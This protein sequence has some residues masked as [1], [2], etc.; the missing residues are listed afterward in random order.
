[1][2]NGDKLISQTWPGPRPRHNVLKCNREHANNKIPKRDATQPHARL[3][4]EMFEPF[5]NWTEA[6]SHTILRK[7]N[8]RTK[9]TLKRLHAS[10]K[11]PRMRE[12]NK[13][14]ATCTWTR[15]RVTWIPETNGERSYSL[16]HTQHIRTHKRQWLHRRK[17]ATPMF[18]NDVF[19]K[20]HF[21][22]K[23]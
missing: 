22:P 6:L 8:P 15:L 4:I 20:D 23:I 9:Q 5:G 7:F 18:F 2:P 19:Q 21:R 11:H 16:N 12:R 3:S 1:M 10:K 17:P 14:L 13:T